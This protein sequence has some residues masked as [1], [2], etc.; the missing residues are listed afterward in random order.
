MSLSTVINS[1]SLRFQ[2]ETDFGAKNFENEKSK[3]KS[4]TKRDRL[5]KAKEERSE[6]ESRELQSANLLTLHVSKDSEK[7]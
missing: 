4:L 2:R 7:I 3:Q 6:N 1:S 5:K